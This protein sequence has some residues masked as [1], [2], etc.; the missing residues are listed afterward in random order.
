[1]LTTEK[2]TIANTKRFLSNQNLFEILYH[3]FVKEMNFRTRR[4]KHSFDSYRQELVYTLRNAGSE[5]YKKCRTIMLSN[6]IFDFLDWKP[7][8]KTFNYV[9][10]A[11]FIQKKCRL[12][13]D[14]FHYTK[15]KTI[16]D[17]NDHKIRTLYGL[18]EK[19]L[20]FK[21][22]N[23]VPKAIKKLMSLELYGPY[24][25]QKLFDRDFQQ[26]KMQYFSTSRKE[27]IPQYRSYYYP[28]EA[29][30]RSYE[31]IELDTTEYIPQAPEV[32]H[33]EFRI[34]VDTSSGTSSNTQNGTTTGD[35]AIYESNTAANTST[36]YYGAQ[37]GT[38]T[39]NIVDH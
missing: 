38:V 28:R 2:I 10:I 18:W 4:K 16:F 29:R 14:L 7:Y 24:F 12:G 17:S 39:W 27:T 33:T 23:H 31:D 34:S 3:A 5:K 32:L 1:M 22:F 6:M 11:N 25:L 8:I 9:A 13:W 15:Q 37:G 19:G 21:D 30:L 26:G 35:Y 20:Y 36:I